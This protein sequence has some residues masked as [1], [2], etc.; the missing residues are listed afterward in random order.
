MNAEKH[1]IERGR[2]GHSR[3][4]AVVARSARFRI[5]ETKPMT[6]SRQSTWALQSQTLHQ[7]PRAGVTRAKDGFKLPGRLSV[8]TGQVVEILVATSGM[9]V[10]VMVVLVMTMTLRGIRTLCRR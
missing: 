8:A 5:V 9:L 10:V 6:T 7:V 1:E 2:N 3:A 4:L